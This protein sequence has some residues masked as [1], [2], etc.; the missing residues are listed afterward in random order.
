MNYELRSESTKDCY[1][2]SSVCV[3]IAHITNCTSFLIILILRLTR[4]N[5]TIHKCLLCKISSQLYTSYC[6]YIISH[7]ATM[8]NVVV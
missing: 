8:A 3:C 1:K 4:C 7:N 6:C 2:F 5:T